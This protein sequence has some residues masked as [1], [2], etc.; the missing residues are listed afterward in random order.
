MKRIIERNG[1]SAFLL[2]CTIT[3]GKGYPLE[4]SERLETLAGE[5]SIAIKSALRRGDL[6]TKYS[7]NQFLVLLLDIKQNDC[8]AVIDR[9][10]AQFENSSRKNYLKYHVAPINDEEK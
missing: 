5:L 2:V 6:Y 7:D 1:Q 4:K 3:D 9:I 8:V 10:N